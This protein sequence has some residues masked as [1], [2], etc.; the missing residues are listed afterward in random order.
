MNKKIIILSVV[1][2]GGLVLL[3]VLGKKTQTPSQP[4]AQAQ[5]QAKQNISTDNASLAPADKIIVANFFGTQ[6]CPSCLTIGKLTKKTLEEK[7]ASEL[8]SGKI[9]FKEINGELPENREIVTKYQARGSSLFVNAIRGESDD[10]QEDTTVWRLVNNE[11]EYI[12]YF[13]NKL[14]TLLGK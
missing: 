4:Q 11:A 3:N 2:I 9:V 7:F 13:E 5:P 1:I 14:N 10:I 6:R 12:S 8:E